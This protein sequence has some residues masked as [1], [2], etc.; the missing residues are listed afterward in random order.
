MNMN[1]NKVM[2]HMDLH[3]NVSVGLI[4]NHLSYDGCANL[5][6]PSFLEPSNTSTFSCC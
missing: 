5:K 3:Y 1:L 6:I 2:Y 4:M